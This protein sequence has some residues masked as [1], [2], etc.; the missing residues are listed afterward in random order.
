MRDSFDSGSPSWPRRSPPAR[1]ASAPAGGASSRAPSIPTGLRSAAII[2]AESIASAAAVTATK[3]SK[4]R[5]S[6]ARSTKASAR[7]PEGSLRSIGVA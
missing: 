5:R 6:T 7:D 3:S 1:A 4:I 2:R